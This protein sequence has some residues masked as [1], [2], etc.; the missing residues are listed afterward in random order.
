MAEPA[1]ASSTGKKSGGG[2]CSAGRGR[3]EIHWLETQTRN[4]VQYFI[5]FLLLKSL[6]RD[7]EQLYQ[8][9]KPD[10]KARINSPVLFIL[11]SDWIVTTEPT[12]LNI[13]Q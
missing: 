5:R 12:D 8:S 9:N 3:L 6:R 10:A 13:H 2:G 11:I 4:T 7:L 1:V